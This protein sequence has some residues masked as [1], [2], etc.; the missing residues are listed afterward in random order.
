MADLFEEKAQTT[1]AAIEAEGGRALAVALDVRRAEEWAAAVAATEG[2]F[3]P[4]SILCNNAGANA[5]VG[6][7]DQIESS[8][9]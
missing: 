9:T 2:A 7:D 6:F 4:V 1:A 5:R 3:G 8:G